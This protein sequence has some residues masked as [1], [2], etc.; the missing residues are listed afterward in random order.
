M[1]DGQVVWL[2]SAWYTYTGADRSDLSAVDYA[3]YLHPDEITQLYVDWNAA[4]AK[5]EAYTC[6]YR[7]RG[8]D[9][10]Y[11][12]FY[13]QIT[14]LRDAVGTLR[15]WCGTGTDITSIQLRERE[16]LR[17]LTDAIP[18]MVSLFSIGG[19]VE[20]ANAQCTSY[21]GADP[22]LLNSGWR[23]FVHVDDH[24]LV[25]TSAANALH[26]PS[27]VEIEVR[28]RSVDGPF[29]WHVVQ[30][31]RL[32]SDHEQEQRWYLTASDIHER[33][34]LIDALHYLDN[35]GELLY[36]S[37]DLESSLQLAARLAVPGIADWCAIYLRADDGRFRPAAIHHADPDK[38]ELAHDLVRRYPFSD[39]TQ[40]EMLRT[41]QVQFHP[42]ITEEMLRYGA[43][44]V[45]HAEMLIR[46]DL[47]SAMV[48]PLI[49]GDDIIGMLQLVRGHQSDPFLPSD[50]DF[51]KLLARRFALAIDAAAAI[52]RERNVADTFQRAA[53]PRTLPSVPGLELDAVYV[54]GAREAEI[55]GDWYDAVTLRDGS[56]LLSIGDVAGK[57]LDAA[58]LMASVRQAIRVAGLQGLDPA[59]ILQVAEMALRAEQPGRFVT[60]FV[61][62][63]SADHRHMRYA[64]AGHPA[65]AVRTAAGV[66]FLRFGGPPLG[67][68]AY[69]YETLLYT[70][71]ELWTLVLYTDGLIENTRDVLAGE[72]LLREILQSPCIDHTGRVA[73]YIRSRGLADRVRDD[74]AILTVRSLPEP[75]WRFSATDAVSAECS[76][77]SFVAWLEAHTR[78]DVAS[79]E[80]IYG[81]LIG[82][83]V[84]HSP[85]QIDVDVVCH[86]DGVHLHVQDSG[87]HFDLDASL[88]E[89]IFAESGR[90]LFIANLLGRHLQLAAL[91]VHGKQISI[92][93]PHHVDTPV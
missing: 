46:L 57:G 41:G 74:T 66:E 14:P 6:E 61:A 3:T 69:S 7:L 75:R 70:I 5:G 49:A 19:K 91:P 47:A 38:V 58:V 76:R 65:P 86:D 60:A 28:L 34:R 18:Q 27:A 21:F 80:L 9:D 16:Y 10:R 56:L 73:H 83:V 11:R 77:T 23:E 71:P 22:T 44:D 1:P 30:I 53:L 40:S 78:V 45:R 90:G 37:R 32:Q 36:A 13:A 8:K 85:G 17:V 52:E 48:V 35:A 54:A 81:E 33:K 89:D 4:L 72:E 12:W 62:V 26:T 20:Y 29:R 55:G 67:V 25:R 43:I 39:Q 79:A 42:E 84:R 82:N 24:D 63:I 88:P 50:V 31:T 2:N 51:A 93:L 87:Q 15:F 92:T 59:A 68:T 64:S